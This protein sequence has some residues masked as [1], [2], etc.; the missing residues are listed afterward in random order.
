MA[1]NNTYAAVVWSAEDVKTL[2]P[3]W[4]TRRCEEFLARR[5]R[6]IQ[7]RVCEL[8][9]EVIQTMLDMEKGN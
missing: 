8:G 6:N 9:W 5:E 3:V 4:S 1:K 2:R 7:D